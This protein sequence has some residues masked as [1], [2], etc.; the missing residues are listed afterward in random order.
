MSC[1][2][3]WPVA[4]P[5]VGAGCYRYRPPERVQQIPH[6]EPYGGI[7]A[8][9]ETTAGVTNTASQPHRAYSRSPRSITFSRR[10]RCLPGRSS[11]RL[12]QRRPM[13]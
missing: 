2:V 7:F 9:P 5:P 1:Q 11:S 10:A 3:Q 8:V 13:A 6:G 4:N 12:P